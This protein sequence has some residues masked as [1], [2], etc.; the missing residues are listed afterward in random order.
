MR[1]TTLIFALAL[2]GCKTTARD[3]IGHTTS[4]VT[5]NIPTEY[6]DLDATAVLTPVNGDG[7]MIVRGKD[8]KIRVPS[9]MYRIA[10]VLS[11]KAGQT[12]YSA[13]DDQATF[14]FKSILES[15]TVPICAV[16]SKAG[17][18]EAG[19]GKVPTGNFGTVQA[20]PDAGTGDLS[21]SP[22]TA[23]GNTSPSTGPQV[24]FDTKC[25]GMDAKATIENGDVVY[26]IDDTIRSRIITNL[27][28]LT[29]GFS[30]PLVKAAGQ[31]ATPIRYK[32]TFDADD[33][34]LAQNLW[35]LA[36][37]SGENKVVQS[38]CE[39][40][41]FDAKGNSQKSYVCAFYDTSAANPLAI[42]PKLAQKYQ[43]ACQGSSNS[44]RF[45]LTL[46]GPNNSFISLLRITEVRVQIPSVEACH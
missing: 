10:L 18:S 2:I 27:T 29:C 14:D 1:K 46:A 38:P 5:V 16:V 6:S 43:S 21:T 3:D 40:L 28:Y 4:S 35:L 19:G 37:G 45:D 20:L 41:T 36:S 25:F 23:G 26:R 13:C 30:M 24:T 17:G 34:T 39:T 12:L 8:L 42:I 11:D 32:I 22:V 7:S 44:Y 31:A 33:A 15:A 9:G